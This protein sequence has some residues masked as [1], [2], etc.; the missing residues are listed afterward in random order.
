VRLRPSPPVSFPGVYG[1]RIPSYDR[2]D[3][4]SLPFGPTISLD[5][6][7]YELTPTVTY[8]SNLETR[9]TWRLAHPGKP[10]KD[11]DPMPPDVRGAYIKDNGQLIDESIDNLKKALELRPDYDDAM[12]YLNLLLRRK[13]DEAGTPDERAHGV[14]AIPRCAPRARS[15]GW[16]DSLAT[17][18]PWSI[19]DRTS[20]NG[21]LRPNHGLYLVTSARPSSAP[22][23]G[24]RTNVCATFDLTNEGAG[25]S[26]GSLRFVRSTLNG[27]IR[28]PTFGTQQFSW[29]RVVYTFGDTAPPQR[30]S[31]LGGSGTLL[32]LR[33]SHLA[34]TAGLLRSDYEVPDQASCASA[35]WRANAHPC[36]I[37]GSA[38]VG[39]L[40]AFEQNLALRVSLSFLRAEIAVDPVHRSWKFGY[41][42][43]GA[44]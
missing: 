35:A 15:I 33:A 31:Y 21:M 4:L 24:G 10:L 13:A 5:T 41:G 26:V 16:T 43:S 34:A 32:T 37:I 3:G 38:G 29:A 12:A 9:G 11:E 14:R 28:F 8:R 44:R 1:I 20:V 7:R 40:P 25:F 30:W 36:A 23:S 42:L 2:S 39:T 27:Q 17:G 19:F 22:D 18:G 6:G